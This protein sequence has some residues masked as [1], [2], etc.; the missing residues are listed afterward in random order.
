M[1]FLMSVKNLD[2]DTYKQEIIVDSATKLE[3]GEIFTPFSLVE[4][5]LNLLPLSIFSNKNLKWLDAA[6]GSGHFSMIVFNRL[7]ANLQSQF[8]DLSSCQDHILKNMMH[9]SEIQERNIVV[10]ENLFQNNV[11]KGDFLS[12]SSSFDIIITNPPYNTNGSIKVPTNKNQDKKGDGKAVWFDFIKKSIE[13]L[14][15]GGH[16]CAIVPSI[17]MKP[18]RRGAYKFLTAYHIEKIHCLD[19]TETNRIFKGHAQTP[20][21]FFHLIKERAFPEILLFDTSLSHYIS[22]SLRENRVIPLFAQSIIT[23]M[24]PFI[25]KV[26]SIKFHRTNLPRKH[27]EFSTTG[28]QTSH[29]PCKNIHTCILNKSN[30]EMVFRYSNKP[31]C[32]FGECKLVLAH[33][34]YGFPYLDK[35][36]GCGIS[37]RDIYVIKDYAWHDLQRWQDFL[38]TKTARYMFEATRYRM[39]YLERYVFELI[40]DITKLDDFP[41]D[42]NDENIAMY[43]GFTEQEQTAIKTRHKKSYIG[44]N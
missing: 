5:I 29:Y 24:I 36:G 13:L 14:N 33:K 16:L 39:K 15:P 22:Y 18:D 21:C 8:P 30:A 35:D 40:P 38:S 26:G 28:A 9:Y 4:S 27:V 34:M 7:L 25:E 32:F 12:L 42:I 23:K 19:N 6:A 1:F 37:N 10:L 31:C 41:M 17:W 43:F 11:I 2:L 3:Y 44:F 20:T